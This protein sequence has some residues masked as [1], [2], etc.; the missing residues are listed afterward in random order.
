MSL[1]IDPTFIGYST[2]FTRRR[3]S[4]RIKF[5]FQINAINIKCI[6]YD[7]YFFILHLFCIYRTYIN[8]A[9]G[10][11]IIVKCVQRRR[12]SI[13]LLS[14]QREGERLPV[15]PVKRRNEQID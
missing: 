6:W 9:D 1:F 7:H 12:D 4:K 3:E 11:S 13:D 2:E 8:Q 10:G 15:F 5:T 14:R